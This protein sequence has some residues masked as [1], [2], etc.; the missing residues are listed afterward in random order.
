MWWGLVECTE[1]AWMT[2]SAPVART[3]TASN[4]DWGR[5]TDNSYITSLSKCQSTHDRFSIDIVEN[6]EEFYP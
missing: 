4:A 1:M 3:K 2:L 5:G 6:N